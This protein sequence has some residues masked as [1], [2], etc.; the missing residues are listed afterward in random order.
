[1]CCPWIELGRILSQRDWAPGE[2]EAVCN[3]FMTEYYFGQLKKYGEEEFARRLLESNRKGFPGNR[4]EAPDVVIIRGQAYTG[5][6]P[7]EWLL[8]QGLLETNPL[9]VEDGY[10][11]YTIELARAI[12]ILYKT[13]NIKD[14]TDK[15][16]Q[17]WKR[18]KMSLKKKLTVPDCG[19]GDFSGGSR[20]RRRIPGG[21][22]ASRHGSG[23]G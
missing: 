14:N 8:L 7:K 21:F 13:P 16:C 2:A 17:L 23:A 11:R 15:T 5:F 3:D 6:S 12:Q 10:V 19:A 20:P 4:V 9:A 1:L 18:A 22:A